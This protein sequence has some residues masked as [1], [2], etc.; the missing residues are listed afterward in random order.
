LFANQWLFKGILEDQLFAS[1]FMNATLRTTTAPTMLKASNKVNVLPIE[2]V[3]T[4]NFRLHPRDTVA[5]V[6]EHVRRVVADDRIEVRIRGGRPA[7][8]VS[9]ARAIGYKTVELAVQ[10]IK[11]TAFMTPGLMI[12]GSDS[13]HYSKISDNSYRLNPMIVSPVDLPK[14]HGTDENIT[15]DNLVLATQIYTRIMLN[16]ANE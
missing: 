12:P 14:I 8:E 11:P 10:E 16:A 7:S 2:A 9:D 1:T 15:V 4:V 13:R 3:A 6:A 5:S